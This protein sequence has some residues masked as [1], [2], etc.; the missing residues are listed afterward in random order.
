MEIQI[1]PLLFLATACTLFGIAYS[2]AVIYS[3]AA[4]LGCLIFTLATLVG[5]WIFACKDCASKNSSS[6]EVPNHYTDS[7]KSWFKNIWS[8]L[9]NW[10]KSKTPDMNAGGIFVFRQGPRI[11]FLHST[12]ADGYMS[13]GFPWRNKSNPKHVIESV[14]NTCGIKPEELKLVPNFSVDIEHAET[15]P[16]GNTNKKMVTYWLAEVDPN[17]KVTKNAS[18]LPY[19]EAI[20]LAASDPILEKVLRSCKSEIDGIQDMDETDY[21]A[22]SKACELG[23]AELQKWY[24]DSDNE[25]L[26]W[27]VTERRK[28]K[29]NLGLSF[30]LPVG[31]F[32]EPNQEPRK[33]ENTSRYEHSPSDKSPFQSLTT[34]VYRPEHEQSSPSQSQ[35][36]ISNQKE[37]PL[38]TWSKSSHEQ[39]PSS[40]T[41]SVVSKQSQRPFKTGNRPENEQSMASQSS[42]FSFISAQEQQPIIGENSFYGMPIANGESPSSHSSSFISKQKQQSIIGE[43]S[44]YGKPINDGDDIDCSEAILITALISTASTI[45]LMSAT[46]ILHFYYPEQFDQFWNQIVMAFD[47]IKQQFSKA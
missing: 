37:H 29:I 46:A 31:Q 14:T 8:Q 30:M 44:F 19:S 38:K 43:N 47:G 16:Q 33:S 25:D 40:Q 28:K 11:E 6:N 15:D 12:N 23:S 5:F 45:L 34:G 41:S 36:F 26:L 21:E 2:D 35:S 10:T 42:S 9:Q 20:L 18:W 22:K 3:P 7:I 17:I 32:E 27:K 4:L 1:I 39:S 13:N 24:K